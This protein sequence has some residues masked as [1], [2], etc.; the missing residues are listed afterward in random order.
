MGEGEGEGSSASPQLSGDQETDGPHL[1][2]GI[3]QRDPGT[4][5]LSSL[6]SVTYLMNHNAAL[7]QKMD[8]NQDS[9]AK[10]IKCSHEATSQM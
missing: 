9:L 3:R 7:L 5:L 6:S 10:K 4:H 8:K 2:P 1:D